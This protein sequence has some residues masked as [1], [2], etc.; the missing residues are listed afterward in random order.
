MPGKRQRISES[1]RSLQVRYFL[2]CNG[3]IGAYFCAHRLRVVRSCAPETCN[4]WWVDHGRCTEKNITVG[5]APTCICVSLTWRHRQMQELRL[6]EKVQNSKE[7]LA[8]TL[9]NGRVNVST[10]FNNLSKNVEKFREQRKSQSQD[11]MQ[12]I[13]IDTGEKP[14]T[15]SNPSTAAPSS[16]FT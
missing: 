8:K 16:R 14:S 5:T 3:E 12:K 1:S 11:S 9:A 10:V 15:D 2:N 6:E 13:S 4:G 7:A